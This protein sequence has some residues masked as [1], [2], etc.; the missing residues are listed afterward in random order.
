MFCDNPVPFVQLV[1]PADGQRPRYP[2][3]KARCVPLGWGILRSP[4]GTISRLSVTERVSKIG[5]PELTERNFRDI[6]QAQ[7]GPLIALICL[8]THRRYRASCTHLSRGQLGINHKTFTDGNR[9]RTRQFLSYFPVLHLRLGSFETL[10][11]F[12]Q[13][14][15]IL[16]KTE[17]GGIRLLELRSISLCRS[18]QITDRR[19]D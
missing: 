12:P 15:G 13:G 17:A 3:A 19:I 11:Q 9:C 1:R 18:A 8:R 4:S 2:G 7:R 10:R 6:R 14:T 16:S 5:D